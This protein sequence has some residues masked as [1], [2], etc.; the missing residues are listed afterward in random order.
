VAISVVLAYR[1]AHVIRPQWQTGSI[2]ILAPLGTPLL[3]QLLIQLLILP[4]MG[5][6]SVFPLAAVG[7][8]PATSGHGDANQR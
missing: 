3:I 8:P 7:E 1:C 5:L 4:V 6:A 2:C